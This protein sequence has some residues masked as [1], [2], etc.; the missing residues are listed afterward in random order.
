[1][2][3]WI[4]RLFALNYVVKIGGKP[5]NFTRSANF[6][7]PSLALT[8][9]SSAYHCPYWW[10]ALLLFLFFAFFG[11]MYFRFKPLTN[12]DIRYFDEPQLQAW[13]FINNYRYKTELKKYNGLWVVLINPIVFI[14]LVVILFLRFS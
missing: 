11:F 7:F 8:M 1:M 13:W 3:K 6:I 14:V 12:D 9:V 10:I 4:V 5:H 2:R